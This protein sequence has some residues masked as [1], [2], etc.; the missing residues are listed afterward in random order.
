MDVKLENGKWYVNG[1]TFSEM[2]YYE[3]IILD[4][5]IKKRWVWN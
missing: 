3:T 5:F 1:K 4:I 2:E